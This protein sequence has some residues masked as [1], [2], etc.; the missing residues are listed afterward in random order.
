MMKIYKKFERFLAS[1]KGAVTLITLFVIAMIIGTFVE[2]YYG[3]SFANKLI[4]KSIPFMILQGLLFLSILI[5]TIDRLP[6]KKRLTG[7]YILH[8]G[9]LIIF[10][11]SAITYFAGI[12]GT[13][14][15]APGEQSQ[16]I[17]FNEDHIYIQN[18][19]DKTKS[20]FPLPNSAFE[21]T[22]DKKV[23]EIHFVKWIPYAGDKVKWK[24]SS[25]KGQSHEYVLFNN[26][27]STKMIFSLHDHTNIPSRVQNGPLTVQYFPAYLSSCFDKGLFFW[28]SENQ[29]CILEKDMKNIKKEI[30]STIE[31]YSFKYNGKDYMFMPKMST[32]PMDNNLTKNQESKLR[33]FDPIMFLAQPFLFI[34]G[35]KMAIPVKK[36]KWVIKDL[37]L[38]KPAG[39]PWMGLKLMMVK[40]GENEYPAKMPHYE[41]PIQKDGKLIEGSKKA[42]AVK[43]GLDEYWLT[44]D[45]PLKLLIKGKR[46]MVGLGKRV[47]KLPFKLTLSKFEMKNNPGT[48]DP[49]SYESFVQLFTKDGTSNHHIFMNNPLKHQN[50]TF[51]QSSYFEADGGHFGSVLSVNSDPGRAMKYLGS[52]LL[53][54]GSM[55]HYLLNKRKFKNKN[56]KTVINNKSIPVQ[57]I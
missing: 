14:T 51:Y 13:V 3:T 19:D 21:T 4:Y 44:D 27:V 35:D 32:F 41:L 30:I 46:V 48:M 33:I 18:V 16:E 37:N 22:L 5:A 42:V 47:T 17:M 28:D 9:L 39:L 50:F 15:L 57:V 24:M 38:K 40:K 7:F 34:F 11:G 26:D 36:E 54:L 53:V 29:K 45:E 52:L 20:D 56:K 2:S 55:I 49:A 43:I 6:F 23:G 31:K 8:S 1:M 25:T 12:D 10:I